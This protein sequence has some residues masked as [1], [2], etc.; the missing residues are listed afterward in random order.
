LGT[1][2]TNLRKQSRKRQAPDGCWPQVS[3]TR[4]IIS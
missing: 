3:S 2:E 1:G 4:Q